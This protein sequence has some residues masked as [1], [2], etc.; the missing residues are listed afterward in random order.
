MLVILLLTVIV[1]AFKPTMRHE[2]AM[3]STNS[4][5]PLSPN[6]RVLHDSYRIYTVCFEFVDTCFSSYIL[7]L[8]DSDPVGGRL[9]S[10]QYRL[11]HRC[12]D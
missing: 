6:R 3:S 7:Q 9:L 10:L 1:A 5:T 4:K 12:D 11:L 2:D 8:L